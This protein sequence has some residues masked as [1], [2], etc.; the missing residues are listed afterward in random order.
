[1]AIYRRYIT[2]PDRLDTKATDS[3]ALILI[4]LIIITGFTNEAMR[5]AI[6][7]FPVFE[8]FSPVGYVLA[9]PFA[10]LSVPVLKIL[11]YINWWVHMLAAFVLL[12]LSCV[13]KGL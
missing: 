6:T 7:K 13:L 10:L 2:K 8:V 5:I 9:Y 3:F 4:L 11:H 12:A 1:M